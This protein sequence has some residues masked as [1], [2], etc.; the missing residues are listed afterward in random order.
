MRTLV[1]V[2][3]LLG[4]AWLGCIATEVVAERCLGAAGWP[5]QRQLAR[6]HWQIDRWVE[7]PLALLTAALGGWGW[8]GAG[9]DGPL[10]LMALAGSA[11]VLANLGCAWLVW[12]RHGCAWEGDVA[13]HARY[14]RWQHRLG[15][16]VALGVLVA[17]LAGVWHARA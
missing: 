9:V 16:V 5:A 8:S 11:A 10:R 12:R 13:G 6:L 1:L 4:A 7:L 3:A 15:S 14:D 17:A 2:H